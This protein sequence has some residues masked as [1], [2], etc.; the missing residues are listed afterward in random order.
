M[1][2][3]FFTSLFLFCIFQVK[4]FNS[5]I[6]LFPNS[7]SK[8]KAFYLSTLN[9]FILSLSSLYF[10]FI[11][12]NHDTL[13]LNTNIIQVLTMSFFTSYLICDL[14]LAIFN[15]KQHIDLLTGYIHHSFYIFITIY[16]LL[17]NNTFLYCLYF[18]SE[19]PTF[20][21]CLGN[22]SKSLRMDKIF[23]FLFFTIRIVY[24]S[25]L[26]SLYFLPNDYFSMTRFLNPELKF[27][28]TFFATSILGLHFYWFSNWYN[29][30]FF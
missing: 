27:I 28:T 15:Y 3:L 18:I 17:N 20:I 30:Y 24:H 1:I 7:S 11:F 26:I 4:V 12:F 13:S 23:G 25:F 19:I 22:L 6:L 8:Q 16:A 9:S 10:N 2:F 29:K 21:L 14:Y 5:L